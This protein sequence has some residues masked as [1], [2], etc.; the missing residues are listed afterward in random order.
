MMM[1]RKF[2]FF[3]VVSLIALLVAAPVVTW[4]SLAALPDQDSVSGMVGLREPDRM[5]ALAPLAP[6]PGGPGFQMVNAFQFRSAWPDRTWDYFNGELFNPG[7]ADN[8]YEAALSI[9]NKVT[10]TKMVVYFYDNSAQDLLVGL[11]RVDPSTGTELEMAT[12]ASVDAQDQHRNA[13]DSSIIEPLVDQQSYSYI[14]EVGMVS[15]DNSL[16]LAAVRIDYGY[17]VTLPSVM[18]NP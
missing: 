4:R 17:E 9:P 11:W 2:A 14:I 18:K 6:V 5:T 7:P 12:V 3:L 13:A 10:I 15:G 16:R 8:F 1:N